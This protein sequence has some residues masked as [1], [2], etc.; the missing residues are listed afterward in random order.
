MPPTLSQVLEAT[1]TSK[2]AF[3]GWRRREL[4]REELPET[5]QGVAR[6]MTRKAAL[7]LAFMSALT[8]VGIDASDAANR[9]RIYL[10]YER[11]GQLKDWMLY[12][13][14][15]DKEK[16]RSNKNAAGESTKAIAETS[17]AK[18]QAYRLGDPEPKSK[19]S[20]RFVVVHLTGIVQQIDALFAGNE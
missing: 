8:A 1:G 14:V 5:T 13:P 19:P 17:L 2:D 6:Q 4:L 3:N 16:Y 9:T 10:V 20:T 12:D 7:E 15:T 11:D 18:N